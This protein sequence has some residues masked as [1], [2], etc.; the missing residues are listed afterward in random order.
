MFVVQNTLSHMETC[1]LELLSSQ[2]SVM[3]M[4]HRVQMPLEELVLC[5]NQHVTG[6]AVCGFNL[7]EEMLLAN[8][9]KWIWF[10]FRAFLLQQ[11]LAPFLNFLIPVYDVLLEELHCLVGQFG[12]YKPQC[13]FMKFALQMLLDFFIFKATKLA[14]RTGKLNPRKGTQK[15]ITILVLL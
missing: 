8:P 4:V 10:G 1:F 12:T 9:F 15:G 6:H 3:V 11:F 13:L 5:R 2:P 14:Y 7:L